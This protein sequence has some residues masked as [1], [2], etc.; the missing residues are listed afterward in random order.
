MYGS[1]EAEAGG[2]H[3]SPGACTGILECPDSTMLRSV[4]SESGA[5]ADTMK[6]LSS[7]VMADAAVLSVKARAPRTCGKERQQLVNVIAR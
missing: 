2:A 5:S 7:G 3:L 4:S 1:K 6:T